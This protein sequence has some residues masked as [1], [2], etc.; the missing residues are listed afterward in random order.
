M[1][2][3]P[4]NFSGSATGWGLYMMNLL[5]ILDRCVYVC[6]CVCIHYHVHAGSCPWCLGMVGPT[7]CLS[8]RWVSLTISIMSIM[9]CTGFSFNQYYGACN[10]GMI[11]G[12]IRQHSRKF[13]IQCTFGYMV[14]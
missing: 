8:C 1:W 9:I 3:V 10:E 2:N 7:C 5:S 13:S 6:V 4:F 14:L 12:I 11:M